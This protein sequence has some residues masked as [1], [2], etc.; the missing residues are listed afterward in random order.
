VQNIS[1]DPPWDAV[2]HTAPSGDSEISVEV[3]LGTIVDGELHH[4]LMSEGAFPRERDEAGAP[5]ADRTRLGEPASRAA[6]ANLRCG[7]GASNFTYVEATWTQTLGNWIGAHTRA[8]AA[9][10]GV[11]H[12]TVIDNAKVAVIKA[13]LY[14]P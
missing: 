1:F 6:S 14:E 9:I 8:L 13:C 10:G 7:D 5:A 2:P 11:P 12:L 4:L 3:K